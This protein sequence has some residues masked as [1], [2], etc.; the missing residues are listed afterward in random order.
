[1][2]YLSEGATIARAN[3]D[4]I[5]QARTLEH[6]TVCMLLCAWA[7]VEFNIPQICYSSGNRFGAAKLYETPTTGLAMSAPAAEVSQGG[8]SIASLQHLVQLIPGVVNT[9]LTLNMNA[10]TIAGDALPEI[11][12]CETRIRLANLLSFVHRSRGS[13]DKASLNRLVLSQDS[14][15]IPRSDNVTIPHTLRKSELAGMFIN[16]INFHGSRLPLQEFLRVLMAVSTGLATLDLSRKQGFYIKELLQRLVPMFIEARKLGAAEMG[17][18]PAA[19]LSLLNNTEASPSQNSRGGVRA[20]LNIAEEVYSISRRSESDTE[21]IE[22]LKYISERLNEWWVDRT[23]G[24]VSLKAE[25]LKL[26]ISLCDA[27]PDPQASLHYMTHLLSTAKQVAT[28]SS[29]SLPESPL[30]TNEEQSRTLNNI[31]RT[32]EACVKLGLHDT[33]ADYWDDFLVRDVRLSDILDGTKLAKHA[34]ADLSMATGPLAESKRDPFI[35]NPFSKLKVT[36]TTPVLVTGETA[37]FSVV[38]QNPLEI[39]VEI[40][41]ISL[42]AEGCDFESYQHSIVLGQLCLQVFTLSGRP[43]TTGSLKIT[44]CRATIKNC[45]ERKFFIF[46]QNWHA[47][48]IIKQKRRIKSPAQILSDQPE[49]LNQP[50]KDIGLPMA[51]EL[52]LQVI[53][54]QPRLSIRESTLIRPSIMLL[55]GESKTFSLTLQNISAQVPVDL[56]LFT[57]D[58]SV[59]RTLQEA[60]GNR[61]LNPA[62]VYEI[63]HQLASKPSARLAKDGTDGLLDHIQP[64]QE[65]SYTFEV[66]GKAGLK[67]ATVLI[68]FACLGRPRSE[69]RE[70]FYTRQIR[71]PISVTVNGSVEIPRC[72]VFPVSGDFAWSLQLSKAE[73]YTNTREESIIARFADLSL[74]T[75]QTGYAMLQLDLRNVWPHP[76][77]IQLQARANPAEDDT[78]WKTSYKIDEVLQPGHVNRVI[79]LVPRIFVADSFAPIPHFTS[80][81]QFVV[82]A[83]KLSIEAEAANRESFWYRE[84]LLK[85][86]KG[87]WAEESTGRHGDLDLRKGIRLSARMIDAL[88][89]DH[90]GVS[91]SIKPATEHDATSAEQNKKDVAQ[92]GISHYQLITDCF[93][94]LVVRVHNR[95][96]ETMRLLLRLQPSLRNQPHNV[97]LELSKRFAWSGVLQRALNPPIEPDACRDIE[98]EVIAL[99]EGDYEFNATVEEIKGRSAASGNIGGVA[100]STE[101]RIWHARQPCLI[102]AVAKMES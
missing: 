37:D 51:E 7:G 31:K 84:E 75:L 19:A 2:R 64:Q 12:V 6:L 5:W 28:L 79:L 8:Q 66:Y 50:V 55:E 67:D 14:D 40:E 23:T 102:D 101:R 95:T 57:F 53:E 17:I 81:R 21:D 16:T 39:D 91:F 78:S 3:S 87:T 80:Q 25:I 59:T 70:M 83:S 9:V 35:F 30:I 32:V 1:M 100:A 54:A 94:T 49:S 34:P 77:S 47:P 22:S 20:I 65:L 62:D 45:R 13:L 68:D 88:K 89:V 46:R 26:C 11:M 36:S 61:E 73:A 72:S 82:N 96:K 4:L 99:A 86:M 60:L 76:I 18:H 90:V 48:Q 27:L 44:G 98:L 15:Y 74:Q 58:D 41:S 29:T 56:L 63:G 93:A 24:D 43:R 92:V 69:V 38:L 71:F 85:H 33:C 52:M 10:A 97:A 42:L